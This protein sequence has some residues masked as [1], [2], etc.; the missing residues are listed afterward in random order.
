MAVSTL[1]LFDLP[2]LFEGFGLPVLEAMTLGAPVITSQSSSLPEVVGSAGILVDPLN[3]NDLVEAMTRVTNDLTLR[4]PF[5]KQS[6]EQAKLFS[7]EKSAKAMLSLY[8]K[9]A[10]EPECNKSL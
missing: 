6:Y 9:V 4:E 10:N 1:F 7:W 5:K 3:E 8:E 2:S